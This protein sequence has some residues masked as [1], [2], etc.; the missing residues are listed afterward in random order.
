MACSRWRRRQRALAAALAWLLLAAL[1]L[2][3]LAGVMTKEALARRFPSPLMVGEK[4]AALP[5]WPLLRQNATAIELVGYAFESVDFA[6]VP[7]FSGT[8]V[9]LLVAID[10]KGSF[11][12]VQ[13]LSHHEPV[14]LEGLGEAP[15][16]RFVEQ[17]RGL[18]LTQSVAIDT[19]PRGG[20]RNEGSLVHIDGVAKATASV[21]IMNQ[22][23][24]ASALKVARARLGFAGAADPDQIARLRPDVFERIGF[25]DMRREGMVGHVI[26]SNR[27]VEAA[28]AGSAGEGLDPEALAK[29]DEPAS[30]FYMALASVPS[31]GRNLLTPASWTRLSDRLEPRDHALLVAYGGRYGVLGGDFVAGTAPDRLL[32]KQNGLAIEMRDL[33]LD[34]KSAEPALRGKSLRVFRIIGQSGLDL[35]QPLDLALVVKRAKGIIY[36]ERINR[37]FSSALRLPARFYD[38]PVANDK[39]WVAIWRQR[40]AELALLA[41]GLAVL[42]VALAR[43]RALVA[44]PRRFAWFRQGYL[45]FTLLF[46]G[47]YAQGQLSI[48]NLTGAL[49]ALRDGRGLEFFLYDPMTV[50][51]W[52]FVFV[53]LLVW[54]R[55]TF[56]GWLCPFGA[57][58]EFIGKLAQRLRLPQLTIRR[59][60]DARLKLLKYL[61][62]ASIL[63]SVFVSAELADKLVEAEPF[64]TAITLNFVRSWPFVLYAG[65]LLAA[66]AVVYKSFCRYL[67]PFG[68]GLAIL[69]RIRLLDW[70]PR[71][72]ECGKPCQTCRHRCEYEAIRPDGGIRYEDCFQCMD[73]VVIHQSDDLC[74]PLILEKKRA[75]V[76]VIHAATPS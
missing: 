30:E 20:P 61:V 2:P 46:I 12:D 72:R 32:L 31:I 9:N 45:L 37:E 60:W 3:A 26:L 21:R 40:W 69:G 1:A 24:L 64:K 7:G 73:C 36:P 58:Q 75:R 35:A 44:N 27:Q 49:Q 17:Y 51:L 11:L 54:G 67:C 14:F 22:S 28:F 41:A 29:P 62:L 76:V 48:V 23:V 42:A 5:I 53:S 52:A 39:G 43:Q 15:M 16:F 57:L 55:G 71:R 63:G 47:W 8:P 70:L 50:S 6:P 74:A 65:A 25:D 56:C 18:S 33:D 68:A 4:D 19:A 10:P 66:S 34:L 59:H 13:V 38:A